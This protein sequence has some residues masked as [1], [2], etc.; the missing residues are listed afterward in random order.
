[1][2]KSERPLKGPSEIRNE[3]RHAPCVGADTPC[4]MMHGRF[5]VEAER[6]PVHH[7]AVIRPR[8]RG[9]PAL[10]IFASAEDGREG[11][12]PPAAGG[13][14]FGPGSRPPA[15]AAGAAV[16]PRPRRAARRLRPPAAVPRPRAGRSAP[17]RGPPLASCSRAAAAPALPC[18]GL[19]AAARRP[20]VGAGRRRRR[21][22]IAPEWPQRPISRTIVRR[23][24]GSRVAPVW[25]HLEADK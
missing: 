3:G 10:L 1:M 18:R 11:W 21:R 4:L 14:P 7:K 8:A 5:A 22:K 2:R 9:V 12:P 19:R 17:C 6:L 20:F 16:R 25:F 23:P 15:A 13:W 24:C